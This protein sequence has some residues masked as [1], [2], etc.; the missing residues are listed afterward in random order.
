M[1]TAATVKQIFRDYIKDN[2]GQDAKDL[3]I[4]IFWLQLQI[5]GGILKFEDELDIILMSH[6]LRSTGYE[7]SGHKCVLPEMCVPFPENAAVLVSCIY[8]YQ[9]EKL[10]AELEPLGICRQRMIHARPLAEKLLKMPRVNIA[11][12]QGGVDYERFAAAH[13]SGVKKKKRI[14]FA[15]TI[16]NRIYF[17]IVHCICEKLR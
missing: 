9:F 3:K 16:D 6:D 13:F 11:F 12:I 14:G 4:Y 15:G 2:F 7:Y 1:N 5:C 8:P 10:C 17:S